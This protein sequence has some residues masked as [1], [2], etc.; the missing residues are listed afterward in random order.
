MRQLPIQSPYMKLRYFIVHEKSR[1]TSQLFA[2]NFQGQTRYFG[3]LPPSKSYPR[4][5]PTIGPHHPVPSSSPSAT[6]GNILPKRPRMVDLR[7][8]T[9]TLVS[10]QA[11]RG[12]LIA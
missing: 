1:A 9:G 12:V 11:G 4:A 6:L 8:C 2:L 5:S 3:R 10:T 7:D